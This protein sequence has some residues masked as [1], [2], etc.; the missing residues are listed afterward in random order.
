M[1]TIDEVRNIIQRDA[2]AEAEKHTGQSYKNDPETMALGFYSHLDLVQLKKQVL[3]EIGDT[4]WGLDLEEHLK[5]WLKEGFRIIYKEAFVGVSYEYAE[6]LFI[7]WHSEKGILGFI[8]TYNKTRVNKSNIYYNV[9]LNSL[10]S[11]SWRY[12]S[13]HTGIS[14]DLVLAGSHDT[15]EGLLVAID[16]LE[17]MGTFMPVW[18]KPYWYSFATYSEWKDTKLDYKAVTA[19]RVM[20]LP[21][22]VQ[23]AIKG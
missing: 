2:L 1:L 10:D 23:N 22:E 12:T 3:S 6:T 15:R 14:D 8:E 5:V 9:K 7:L 16:G 17:K 18:T 21:I 11:Y 20:K 4:H 19:D 13:S